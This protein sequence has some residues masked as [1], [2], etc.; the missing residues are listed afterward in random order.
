MYTSGKTIPPQFNQR[1]EKKKKFKILQHLIPNLYF[2]FRFRYTAEF[3]CYSDGWSPDKALKSLNY[4]LFSVPIF[5]LVI[6]IIIYY[7]LAF[8]YKYPFEYE[9]CLERVE[10]SRKDHWVNLE[11]AYFITNSIGYS[12]IQRYIQ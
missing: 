3:N 2:K 10:N 1:Y 9:L 11:L 8:W 6:V 5:G 12:Q 7:H 4:I